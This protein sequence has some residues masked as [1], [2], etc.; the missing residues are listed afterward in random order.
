MTRSQEEPEPT[1]EDA[2]LADGLAAVI[3]QMLERHPPG[4]T[5][6]YGIHQSISPGMLTHLR[7]HFQKAGWE[8]VNVRKGATGAHLLVLSGSGEA[9]SS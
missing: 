1:S 8:Y 2:A 6:L 4:E 5:F 9:S 3:D 7:R